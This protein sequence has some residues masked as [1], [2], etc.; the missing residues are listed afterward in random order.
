[1]S[2]HWSVRL[3][4]NNH[5]HP[6]VEV[7]ADTVS[8]IMVDH[9]DGTGVF[10]LGR[11]IVTDQGGLKDTATVA[12]FPEVDLEPFGLVT[13]PDA[14]RTTTETLYEFFIANH[15]R[16]QSPRS[17]WRLMADTTLI[18]EGDTALAARDTIRIA[19]VLPPT[20]A[21]GTYVLRVVVDTLGGVV[22][23]NET[24]NGFAKTITVV[25]PAT[26]VE[27]GPRLALSSPYPNPTRSGTRLALDLPAAT[28]VEFEVLDIQGRSVWSTGSRVLGAGRTRLAWDGRT[29]GGRRASPGLYLARVQLGASPAMVRR[30]V[31]LE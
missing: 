14:P 10:Y 31:V 24:N 25:G 21:A 28:M 11:Y 9:E 23:T 3:Y 16:L 26:S 6:E 4:H 2:G 19:R 8:K 7:D 13:V 30:F 20:L 1:L 29:R 18:A 15:G 12:I 5:F 17:R 27:D 22:E